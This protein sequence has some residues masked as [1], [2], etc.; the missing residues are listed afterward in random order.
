MRFIL[1]VLLL[2]SGLKGLPAEKFYPQ[3]EQEK[4]VPL[5][6]NEDKLADHRKDPAFDYSEKV[7][8]ENWW[9]NF[10]RYI[11]LQWQRLIR[12]LFGDYE[13]SAL[14]VFF[15][16]VL[17]YLL[18]AAL[19]GFILYLFS[20]LNPGA[21]LLRSSQKG[22]VLLHQD[23]EIIRF[24]NI[25]ELISE[26]IKDGNY[27]LAIR[28]HFLYVL[29]QLS[30]KGLVHF[31]AGKTDEDYLGEIAHEDLKISFRKV[32]RI[33]DFIWYGEFS[34]D[35]EVY[36]KVKTDFRKAENLILSANE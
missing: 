20:K 2:F 9:T 22:D 18:L 27:R 30:E 7:E 29:Q 5:E 13:A 11:S 4:L 26:A 21:S 36:E 34:A 23:E 35:A 16:K 1:V 8:E 24:G 12:W 25:K 28:Y 31:D 32:S 19:L 17:P 14:L 6:F 15:L 3:D 10:K 33:Y